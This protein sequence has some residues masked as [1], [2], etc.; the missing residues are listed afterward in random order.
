MTN[1]TQGMKGGLHI[2]ADIL[3]GTSGWVCKV[4]SGM[5]ELSMFL[6]TFKKKKSSPEDMFVD[7]RGERGREGEGERETDRKRQI[8]THTHTHTQKY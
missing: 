5:K 4:P 6:V 2:R 8:H 3:G 1:S 7:F